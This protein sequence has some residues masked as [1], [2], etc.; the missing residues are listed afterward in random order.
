VPSLA[1]AAALTAAGA[2]LAAVAVAPSA[3]VPAPEP[4]L[5]R[6][7]TAVSSP[8]PV[9][10][11]RWAWPLVPRPA[12]LRGFD[13]V[14]RYAAGH[15]GVDLAAVPGQPVLA[16]AAGTVVFAGPVAG[17]GVL[18]LA[19]ADGLRSSV[20][21]VVPGVAVGTT[22]RA[23][24]VVA[25]LAAGPAHCGATACLHLGVRRGETYLDPLALLLPANPPVLLPLGRPG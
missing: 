20:E 17:R 16:P 3:A 12:V 1:T 15:R 25:A 5:S 18:V 11:A 22:V 2:A 24:D 14:G 21:P 4:P 19:H 8:S 23:G 9:P 13:D 10:A 6:P 7:V